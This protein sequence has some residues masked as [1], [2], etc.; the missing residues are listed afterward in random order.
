METRTQ[1]LFLTL[2]RRAWLPLLLCAAPAWAAEEPTL[3]EPDVRPVAVDE[4]LIDTENF[5]VGAFTGVLNIEDF[6]SSFVYGARLGY[7][8]SE[9]LFVESNI[10]F[11]EGGE[12]S[13]EQL[14]GD[15]EL[16]TDSE[17]EYVYYN[18]NFGYRLL[19]GEA[20]F[21]PDHAF[22]TNFYLVAGAGA[23][24]FAGDS[25]FT[26]NVG[27]GYQVLFTDSLAVEL[28][29]REHM[30]KIDVLGDEKTAF[31]TEIRCAL[32]VFF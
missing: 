28:G 8:L 12:T 15:V 10:G 24:D 13:F 26:T 17:R 20:F 16:L 11:A 19:P 9:S 5:E 30:Y 31:N 7:N 22:N 3:I 23:T 18:L 25:R 4:A 1:H 21:G 2:S 29:V 14:A 6:G 27:F 32:S